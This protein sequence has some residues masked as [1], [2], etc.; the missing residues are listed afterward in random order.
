MINNKYI[1]KLLNPKNKLFF[2]YLIFF[3]VV[4]FYIINNKGIFIAPNLNSGD[5]YSFYHY[6]FEDL[7]IFLSQ[8]RSFGGPIIIYL[9]KFFDYELVYWSY[10]NF[11][12]F[13]FSLLFLLYSLSVCNFNKIFSFFF[14]IGILGSTKLWY[15]FSGWSEVLSV[16]SLIL[17]LSF[18]L[19]ILKKQKLRY[20][21][22]FTLF[23]F[24][25]YQIRPLLFMIIFFFILLDIL[26]R[27]FF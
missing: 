4:V 16:S 18:Y 10:F 24:F 6:N 15:L 20:Y 12:I 5:A 3:Q 23:V 27:K 7:E 1:Y 21:F 8:Y 17:S 22:L 14:V 26:L 2:F 11:F 13:N 19:L 9:Y 25:S